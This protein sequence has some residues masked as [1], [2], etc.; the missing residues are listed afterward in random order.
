M[1]LFIVVIMTTRNNAKRVRQLDTTQLTRALETV[2]IRLRDN[3]AEPIEIVVCGGSAL[4]LTGVLARTT[5]DVDIV[6][7]ASPERLL[8]PDPLPKDLERAAA[9]AAEDLGLHDDW[10]NNGPSRGVGGLFQMGLPEG[11]Q[12][13]WH[14]RRYG[15]HLTVHFIG[16]LDQIHFKLYAA[17]DRG[18]YHVE[19]LLA[20][21]PTSDELFAAARWAMSHDVSEGFASIA[22]DMLRS[23]GHAEVAD[24]L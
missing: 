15:S 14:T 18:G 16:R 21:E 5:R 2:S 9:E 17:V 19:D 13:R 10:L 3:G 20:L 24:R 4:I 12:D 22:K 8:S 1:L 11:L 23:I 6:A 7:L